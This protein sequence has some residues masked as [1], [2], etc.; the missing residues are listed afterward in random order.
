MHLNLK[1]NIIILT[2]CDNNK[3]C[4][5]CDHS[6]NS[7]TCLSCQTEFNLT[8]S[9]ANVCQA[10]TPNLIFDNCLTGFENG[11]VKCRYCDDN[12]YLNN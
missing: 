8:V 7:T 4:K 1:L 9:G 2:E 3:W 12:Y 5:R 10:V 6:E 11:T